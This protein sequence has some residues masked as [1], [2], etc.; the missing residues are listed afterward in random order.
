MNMNRLLFISQNIINLGIS[1]NLNQAYKTDIA[2][3]HKTH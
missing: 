2:H 1:F 3:P